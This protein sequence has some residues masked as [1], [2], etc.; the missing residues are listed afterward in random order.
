YPGEVPNK[1]QTINLFSVSNE[2]CALDHSFALILPSNICTLNKAGEGACHGDSGGPL[3]YE[4]YQV[5]VV[6][7]GIPCA[8]GRPDVFTR[9]YTYR[10]WIEENMI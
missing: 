9:V 3:V 2:K 8:K 1:L 5:G 10:K 6:S 4:D 7:W